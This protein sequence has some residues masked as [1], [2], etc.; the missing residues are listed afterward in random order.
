MFQIFFIKRLFDL[1]SYVT[2]TRASPA[3]QPKRGIERWT[4]LSHISDSITFPVRD[5]KKILFAMFLSCS[6]LDQTSADAPCK[7]H[8]VNTSISKT[9]ALGCSNVCVIIAAALSCSN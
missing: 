9:A 7:E 1:A 8:S 3:T 5:E 6:S 2:H 4:V